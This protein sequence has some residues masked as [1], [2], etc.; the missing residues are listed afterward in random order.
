MYTAEQQNE[1]MDSFALTLACEFGILPLII[2]ITGWQPVSLL[3][4]FLFLEVYG[5]D[6]NAGI[7]RQNTKTLV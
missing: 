2:F 3:S 4:G 5:K 6:N 1:R 7:C